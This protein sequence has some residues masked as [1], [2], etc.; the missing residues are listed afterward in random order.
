MV[1]RVRVTTGSVSNLTC[2]CEF[3]HFSNCSVLPAVVAIDIWLLELL[4]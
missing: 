2:Q 1:I 3:M 4:A